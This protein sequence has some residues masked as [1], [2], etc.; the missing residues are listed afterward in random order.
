VNLNGLVVH[1]GG[2]LLVVKKSDG[3]LFRVPLENPAAFTKVALSRPI[4]GAD[5]VLLTN[6]AELVV[7]ANKTPDA[8]ANA[9]LVLRSDDGWASAS[10]RSVQPLG[11]VYPTTATLREGQLLVLHSNLDELLGSSAEQRAGLARRA[12]L[13][14]LGTL[15]ASPP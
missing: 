9:A 10:I 7:I 4:L 12:T 11:S 3:A 14:R 15:R 8:V 13:R 6:P 5:G 1:P 2:F